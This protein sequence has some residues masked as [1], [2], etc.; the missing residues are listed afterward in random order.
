MS[1]LPSDY[2]FYALLRLIGN[3]TADFSAGLN[4]AK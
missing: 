1:M 2:Q 3:G 4:K